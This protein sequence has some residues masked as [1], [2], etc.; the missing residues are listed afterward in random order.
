M[1]EVTIATSSR[2]SAQPITG[3]SNKEAVCGS[4]VCTGT[5]HINIKLSVC[6]LL[7]LSYFNMNRVQYYR[8]SFTNLQISLTFYICFLNSLDIF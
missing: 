7:S 5:L 8:N 3:C 4:C 6:P 1:S 2:D